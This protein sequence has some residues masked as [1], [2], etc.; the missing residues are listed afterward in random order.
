MQVGFLPPL[1]A[2][3][4]PSLFRFFFPASNMFNTEV[5]QQ[6]GLIYYAC[7]SG[8][9]MNLNNILHVKKKA[10]TIA[11][12]GII[13]PMVM[14]LA[15]YLLHRKFYGNSDGSELEENTTKAYILWTLVL[16]VTGFPII[17][18]TLSEF[19]L[20][21]TNLGKV[22]LTAYMI[23]DTYAWILFVLFVPFAINGKGAIYPV[24]STIIFVFICI[25]VVHPIIVKV[26]DRKT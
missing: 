2:S 17:A 13:F 20:L 18:H 10:A 21:Y 25:F 8:L 11:V 14:G 9:E 6:F 22:A 23:S 19:K 3:Y 12:F 7:R 15:L 1:L 5:L 24:L 4:Y 16:T 26:I